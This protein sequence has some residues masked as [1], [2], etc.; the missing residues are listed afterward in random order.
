MLLNLTIS[1]T[2]V[3]RKLP[4]SVISREE[5]CHDMS[6]DFEVFYTEAHHRCMYHGM[7]LPEIYS[8]EEND[9]LQAFAADIG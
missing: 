1:Y 3:L 6:T 9:R 4:I 8:Q 7:T 5:V 2:C